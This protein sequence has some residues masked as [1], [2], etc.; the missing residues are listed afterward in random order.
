MNASAQRNAFIILNRFI[1]GGWREMCLCVYVCGGCQ[2]GKKAKKKMGG[3][4]L[5]LY[6]TLPAS[7]GEEEGRH[8][9]K[10]TRR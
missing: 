8:A 2:W 1:L 4:L 6:S 3:G 7:K 5:S 10:L 9:V